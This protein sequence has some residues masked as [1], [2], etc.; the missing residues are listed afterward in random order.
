MSLYTVIG[1]MSGTS[2]DGIDVVCATFEFSEN[3]QCTHSVKQS[4]TFKYPDVILDKL[5]SSTQL[6]HPELLIL[7]KTLGI[8]FS[9]CILEFIEEFHLETANID[10]IASHGHTI[11]HQPDK[12]FTYQIGCGET[13]AFRTGIKVINDFRQKDVVAGGQ[14]APLVPI[15]DKLLYS[16]F[17]DAF[18]NIGG[19]CNISIPSG[20]TIAFDICP[21]NL[22]LNKIAS[23]QGKPY[24]EGGL[25]ARSGT[26][27][28][29]IMNEL[30]D[31]NYYNSSPPK[32]LG[33][34][35]IE[36]NFNPIV[37]K[38]STP[39]DRM[40]T[41]LEHI[42]E[43]ISIA[44]LKNKVESLYITGGGAY[45]DFLIQKI[46]EK[47]KIK[48][49]IPNSIEIEFKEAIIFGL[50]GALFLEGKTNTLSSV[51]GASRD[52]MGGVLHLP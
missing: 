14:G 39:Q 27:D 10:A 49:V 40:R 7:D 30:N 6:Q 25:I 37:S 26:I 20:H 46:Q 42:A 28:P 2:M 48:I 23:E 47:S 16:Q 1:V 5:I 43:Q 18:L 4:K 52:V 44:C 9:D 34:E 3:E 31:L 45:N 36:A 19:F 38:I 33:T 51:T 11:F 13:I 24:D 12:R 21:G 22:P 17:A 41:V 35:W 29:K 32:S 50:L 15:G 8:Y